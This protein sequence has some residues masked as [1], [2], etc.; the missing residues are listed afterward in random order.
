MAQEGQAPAAA[1]QGGAAPAPTAPQGLPTEE[2]MLSA[3]DEQ[4][5]AGSAGNA[6]QQGKPKDDQAAPAAGADDDPDGDKGFETQ[7]KDFRMPDGLSKRIKGLTEQ[8]NKAREDAKAKADL[9]K[10]FEFFKGY[11]DDKG[12]QYLSTLVEFDGLL[13]KAFTSNP[14]LAE[15]VKSVVVEGNGSAADKR[16]V[17]ALIGEAKAEAA[18]EAEGQAGTETDPR[19]KQLKE[20]VT[21]KQ[22]LETQQRQTA[23]QARRREAVDREKDTYRSEIS[24]FEK[25][26]PQF[27]GD[28][29]FTRLALQVSA[30]RNI[31][32][33]EA[34][35]F[36]SNYIGGREKASLKALGKVDQERA[37]AGVEAPG[38]GGVPA[39]SRPAIGSDEEAAEME[40]YFGGSQ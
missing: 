25:S 36:M 14:W 20:L 9:E 21:W 11:S 26:N 22:Q 38:R 4:S 37:G 15:L 2:Q 13:E 7:F 19:D 34:A 33:T 27:K 31:S 40:A 28:K 10:Q 8:R 23:E 30:A 24:D 16:K 39:K 3:F 12:K 5:G 17:L 35:K 29:E 18:E 32:F 1:P 6:D